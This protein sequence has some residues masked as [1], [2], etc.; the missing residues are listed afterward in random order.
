MISLNKLNKLKL[1]L[2]KNIC[3]KMIKLVVI[4]LKNTTWY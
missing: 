2:L 1:V 3:L 4:I